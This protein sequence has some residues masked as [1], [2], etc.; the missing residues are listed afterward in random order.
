MLSFNSKLNW[1]TIWLLI[2]QII[3]NRQSNNCATIVDFIKKI[4]INES[5]IKRHKISKTDFTR[6][7]SLPFATVFIFLINLLKSSIQNE[8]DKFFKTINST[9]VPQRE[10]TASAFCQARKKLNYTAFTELLH[11]CV[12]LFYKLFP[13]KRWHGFR[14]LALDGSTVQLP[15]EQEIKQHFGCWHPARSTDPCPMARVSQ[16]FDVLNHITID[17]IMSPKKDGERWLAAKHFEYLNKHDLVLSDRG[18]PAFWYFRLIVFKGANYCARLPIERWSVILKD[19]LASNLKET[20]IDLKPSYLAIKD[21]EKLGLPTTPLKVRLIPIEFDNEK[22]EVLAT[23]LIDYD[24]YPYELFK[25]LYFQRWP[26][27]EDYKLLKSRLEIANFTGKSVL[28]VQQ[29]FYARVFMANLTS[30]LAFPI[31]E[32]IVEKHENSKLEYK[33][34]WT[35]A[36]AKMRESGILLFFRNNIIDIIKKL[37]QLFVSDNSAIRPGRKFPRKYSPHIKKYYFAYKPIS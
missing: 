20:I 8:L 9:D 7:R 1:R 13:I 33:I 36:L 19:F 12:E 30:M 5:F 37:W 11:Q 29:D 35:Q 4:L 26:V 28:A 34:N 14:L 18:Y 31:H 22:T 21:C 32:K 24:L 2:T 6:K 10:V 27:E 3:A 17:T 16:M 23:S 15:K 25:E